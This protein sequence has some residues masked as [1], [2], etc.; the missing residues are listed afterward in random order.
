MAEKVITRRDFLRVSALFPLSGVLA[1]RMKLTKG[2]TSSGQPRVVLIRDQKALISFK[3]PDPE[4]VQYMLDE[5]VTKLLD[6]RDPVEAWKRLVNASDIVGIKTNVM[7]YLPTTPEVEQAI[8]KRVLD[9][10][11]SEQNIS[12]DD[13]GVRRNPVFQK[14]TAIINARPARTH[15]WAGMGGCIKNHIMFV[16]RAS[17]YHPDSCADLATLWKEFNLIERTKLNILVMLNPQFHTV[18]PHSYND[19][20]VWEYKGIMVS[21]DPVAVDTLGL[22]IIEAKRREYFGKDLPMQTPAKHIRIADTR[23]NLGVSDPNKIEL[24]KLGWK[25]NILI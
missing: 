1:T 2:P 25:E 17:A 5:A 11:V 7:H 3:K 21:Q 8:K 9:V 24:I 10:G 4:V 18:G 19:K 15:H 14:A 16:P 20:Y 23:H 12:I 13:R 6:E 22:M